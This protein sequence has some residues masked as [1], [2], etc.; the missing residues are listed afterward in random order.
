MGIRQP[1][2]IRLGR[3]ALCVAWL[4]MTGCALHRPVHLQDARAAIVQYYEGG[5][6]DREIQ[7]A[8]NRALTLVKQAG[9]EPVAPTLILDVDDTAISTWEYQRRVGL[10]FYYPALQAWRAE[11][12]APPLEPILQVSKVA[13][14]LG[15]RLVF[16]TGRRESI[17]T[18]TEQALRQAGYSG[19]ELLVM[20]PDEARGPT[21]DFKRDARA[22]L[23]A[24]GHRLYLSIG[25]QP[26]DL[27]GRDVEHTILLP[28]L[29]YRVD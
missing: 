17:R 3:L 1:A 19:W 20:K 7:Q 18:E 25:D 13:R 22:Q 27:I 10:G 16:L 23:K 28:N 12:K 11:A 4:S 14:D 5:A 9:I 15:F 26:S 21:A 29:I 6:Y 2:A 24:A 8:G